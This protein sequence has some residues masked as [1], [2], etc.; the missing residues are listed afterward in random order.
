ML[1]S[2]ATVAGWCGARTTSTREPLLGMPVGACHAVPGRS[3]F[4]PLEP[5]AVRLSEIT[6][7]CR[8]APRLL[9]EPR[10]TSGTVGGAQERLTP[11]IRLENCSTES[12]LQPQSPTIDVNCSS[13]PSTARTVLGLAHPSRPVCWMEPTSLPK[14]RRLHGRHVGYYTGGGKC[15]SCQALAVELGWL[16]TVHSGPE[17]DGLRGD[18]APDAVPTADKMPDATGGTMSIRTGRCY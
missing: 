6:A 12:V 8:L 9:H 14:P 5:G 4:P 13:A 10:R 7:F 15:A 1:P 16:D 3:V 17:P 18:D 11:F 2:V